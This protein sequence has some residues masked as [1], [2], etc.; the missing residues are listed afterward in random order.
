MI[1]KTNKIKIYKSY[2]TNGTV[3]NKDDLL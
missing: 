1:T 3:G 2:K